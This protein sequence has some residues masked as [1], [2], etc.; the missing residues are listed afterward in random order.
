MSKQEKTLLDAVIKFY[1]GSH[2]FNGLPL[3]P[4][5][6]ESDI[7]EAIKLTNEGLV[8]VMTS[9]DYLNPHIR[10]WQSMRSIEEQ[11]ESLTTLKDAGE[12]GLACLYPTHKAMKGVRLPG[13]Y[14][15]RPFEKELAK[16]TGVLELAFF[17]T[18]V[19]EFYRNDP[20]YECRI[21]D[22]SVYMSVSDDVYGDEGEP[23]KDKVSL[24]HAGFAYDL[25]GFDKKDVNSPIIRR[26]AVFVGDLAR[27]SP[28]HQ[29]RW[30][31]FRVAD[32]SLR[33][34]PTWFA[35]QMGRWTDD[36]GPFQRLFTEM[37]NI[38]SLFQLAFGKDLFKNIERPDEMG[39]ILRA[40]QKE[41]DEQIH[42]LDKVL[43][44]NINHQALDAASVP[45]VDE[46][47]KNMGSLQRLTKL[48]ELTR[49]S[50]KMIESTMSPLREVR[51]ARQKPA[52]AIRKNLND[53]TFVHKQVALMGRVSGSMISLRMWLSSH[54]SASKWKPDFEDKDLK[55]LMF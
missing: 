14:T 49:L 50:S 18:D 34:H 55:D 12:Y 27:L 23:D 43:S 22:F 21:D 52:H 11:V 54:P 36:I 53:K 31:T 1:L 7:A 20:R 13:R 25:S 5:A 9:D 8:Q 45:K 42:L 26:L 40:S 17:T 47:G 39:W 24:E 19:L 28:E 16:G 41:W 37:K 35:N 10:P 44:E 33:P 38:N 32:E 29:Q 4:N 3:R 6:D 30:K 46:N 15:D 51:T 2:D 48:M